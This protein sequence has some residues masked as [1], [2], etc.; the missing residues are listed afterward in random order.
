MTIYPLF[1]FGETKKI[2]FLD[3]YVV[4][5]LKYCVDK[6]TAFVVKNIQATKHIL[7]QNKVSW[8]KKYEQKITVIISLSL[9]NVYLSDLGLVLVTYSCKQLELVLHR[10]LLPATQ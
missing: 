10:S 9:C 5:N 6:Y 3:M 8:E 1:V 2:F 7:S 4:W